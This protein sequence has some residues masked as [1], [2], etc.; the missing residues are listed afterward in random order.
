MPRA[1]VLSQTHNHWGGIEVWMA[2]VLPFLEE[3]G[4]TIE[5]G[6]ALGRCHNK[7]E[8]FLEHHRYMQRTHVMDGRAETPEARQA[9]IRKLL[10][11][12]EPDVLVPVAIGDALPAL[13]G[14]R[15]RGCRTKVV[16]PVHSL[17][18]GTLA[19]IAAHKDQIDMTAV[20]SGLLYRWVCEQLGGDSGRIRWIRNGVP[21]AATKRIPAESRALRVGYVG[22]LDPH[23]K[24]VRDV[25]RILEA[26]NA[27]GTALSMTIVG[28]GPAAQEMKADL[29]ALEG[30]TK[31]D[32]LGYKPRPMLYESIYPDL[33]CLLLTSSSEGSP[34]SVIEAMQ[35]GVVPVVSDFFGHAAEGL[36]QPGFNCLTFPVGES[37]KAA[38]NLERLWKD[39][40]LLATLSVNARASV[41]A[42]Y[43]TLTMQR[44]WAK[45]FDDVMALPA[46]P[47]PTHACLP[48][49][50]YGRLDRWGFPASMSN[51]IRRYVR[52]GHTLS[53]GFDEWPGSTSTDG[54]ALT[55]IE[56]ELRSI[57]AA[58]N[59]QMSPC[60]APAS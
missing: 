44:G 1:L 24:R 3:C 30:P 21:S 58:C 52:A 41:E 32:F 19:D 35:N 40:G 25:V 2:E 15:A 54:R 38:R 22:R 37:N 42:K 56:N 7:P 4:W 48:P 20:V 27:N 45:A 51:W 16:L 46:L 43:D 10:R 23:I 33:D 18:S 47:A 36:L 55:R 14:Q 60:L 50:S 49:A 5:Y 57:E 12:I 11:E 17:H 31:I 29:G 9:A 59:K 34:L 53:S 8:Q 26:T 6:L 39:P 13:R 28:D